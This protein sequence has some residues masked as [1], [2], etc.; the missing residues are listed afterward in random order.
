MCIF[1]QEHKKLIKKYASFQKE[2][3][4]HQHSPTKTSPKIACL[5]YERETWFRREV[6]SSEKCRV[7]IVVGLITNT[8]T[9]TKNRVFLS[10]QCVL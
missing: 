4:N 10:C 6:I 9:H 2:K 8:L 5:V 1:K 3:Q 7:L